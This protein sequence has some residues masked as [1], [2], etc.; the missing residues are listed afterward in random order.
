[1]TKFGVMHWFLKQVDKI[2]FRKP[3][4]I[5]DLLRLKSRVVYSGENN[6]LQPMVVVEV[7]CHVVRPEKYVSK[8]GK[9]SVVDTVGCTGVTIGVCFILL[10]CRASS[11]VSNTFHF[12]FGFPRDTPVNLR[13]VL[14]TTAEEAARIVRTTTVL[15]VTVT[16][17]CYCS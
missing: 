9:S 5:G 3:V 6:P 17:N 1:V 10:L 8:S 11:F 12:V 15:T 7:T 16:C 4:D 14:P 13:R 2:A